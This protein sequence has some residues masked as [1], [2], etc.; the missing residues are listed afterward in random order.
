[1]GS[2]P[3]SVLTHVQYASDDLTRVTRICDFLTGDGGASNWKAF[4]VNDT[5][6]DP[7]R[8][9]TT[10]FEFTDKVGGTIQAS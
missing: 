4:D 1:M 5:L 7:D 2:T 9:L 8:R 10:F 3:G 6:D